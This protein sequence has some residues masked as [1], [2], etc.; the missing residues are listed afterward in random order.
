MKIFFSFLVAC[1]LTLFLP[2][3]V[4]EAWQKASLGRAVI[5]TR[6]R[7]FALHM[8]TAIDTTDKKLPKVEGIKDRS[9]YLHTPLQEEMQNEEIFLG[10][11]AVVVLKYHGS[12]MQDNR[13]KRQRGVEKDYQF[14]LRLKVPGGELPSDVYLKLDELSEKFG[15][16]DLRATTRQAWQLHGVLK[17]DLK[18][19]IS[20]IME[21]GSSTVG[22]CGD[23]NRNVMCPAAP[24]QRKDYEAARTY[25]K[26]FAE[27]FKPQSTAFTNIWLKGENTH[28]GEVVENEKVVEIEHW[29]KDLYAQ[30]V[31]VQ[32]EVIKQKSR[33]ASSSHAT[34]NLDA[35]YTKDSV[36]PLYGKRYLPRKFKIGVTVPGDNSVDLY[37]NDLGLVVIMSPDG[38]EVQGFNVMVGGGMG[39]THNKDSTF[40]RVADHLGYVAKEDVVDLCYAILATQ[41]DHGNREVRP[42]A[43][44]KY[45]VHEKGINDFRS[46]VEV[47]N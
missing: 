21:V 47:S 4:V 46:L 3:S 13:D 44:M 34:T 37:T 40:A 30:G 20:T 23:V 26:L 15:Q 32:E 19:V 39:R 5:P 38:Q 41:R 8:S 27:L 43:R 45:L 14:M 29:V 33:Q 25:S 31:D 18:T 6:A 17:S 7:P 16:G 28:G 35:V 2:M 24:F 12:Y 11:D 10:A 22:A 9:N 1:V 42:N 36:E